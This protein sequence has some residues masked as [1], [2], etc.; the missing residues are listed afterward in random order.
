[1]SI[2]SQKVPTNRTVSTSVAQTGNSRPILGST[3]SFQSSRR[4]SED[5][6]E[7]ISGQSMTLRDLRVPFP[8]H[9]LSNFTI[10]NP[11]FSVTKI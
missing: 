9:F 3:G 7:E 5:S 2:V 11:L 8:I 4:G 6:T 1:M 10:A